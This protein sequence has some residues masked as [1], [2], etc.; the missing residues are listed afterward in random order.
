M[1]LKIPVS[2]PLTEAQA[3]L[4][5]KIGSMKSLLSLPIDVNL[6]IPKSQQISTFDYLIKVMRAMGLDPELIF[7]LFS[8][9]FIIF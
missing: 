5:S 3:E 1:A 4:T 2:S 6:N 9:I 8:D 7:N